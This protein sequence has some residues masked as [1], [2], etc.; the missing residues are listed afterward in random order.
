MGIGI[1]LGT[2]VGCVLC[3]RAVLTALEGVNRNINSIKSNIER[4]KIE[5]GKIA[6]DIDK[7]NQKINDVKT[8][9]TEKIKT[10]KRHI[11]SEFIAMSFRERP[12]MLIKEEDG[13][14]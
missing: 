3:T 5:Q 8:G 7:L 9:E 13:G 4:V 6:K 2:F 12:I 1:C 11:S 10:L 14:K